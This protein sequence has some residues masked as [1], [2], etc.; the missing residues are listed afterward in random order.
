M[1]KI[2]E[3]SAIALQILHY[4]VERFDGSIGQSAPVCP[5]GTH[6]FDHD[7]WID[8]GFKVIIQSVSYISEQLVTWEPVILYYLA[9]LRTGLFG[10]VTIF[11]VESYI[12]LLKPAEGF[13]IR[14]G[15][16]F[17]KAKRIISGDRIVILKG[18]R[19]GG[20]MMVQR[21][22]DPPIQCIVTDES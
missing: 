12:F 10:V 1:F 3:T 19:R 8:D 22:I 2:S 17:A 14:I 7:E 4:A 11:V 6:P 16:C 15:A 5:A 13:E 9:E 21:R 20:V 18:L